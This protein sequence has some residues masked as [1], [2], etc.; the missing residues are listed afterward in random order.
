[1]FKEKRGHLPPL[2]YYNFHCNFY[3]LSINVSSCLILFLDI[4]F[5]QTVTFLLV[6]NL[7]QHTN[8]HCY[9]PE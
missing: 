8:E 5:F 6:F 4:C 2:S 1:M 7:E 9:Y 3:A